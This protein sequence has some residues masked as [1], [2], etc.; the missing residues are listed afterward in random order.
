MGDGDEGRR[1]RMR[2]TRGQDGVL[3]TGIQGERTRVIGQRR[4]IL[5]APGKYGDLSGS[6]REGW[7][8]NVRTVS[9]GQWGLG[10]G[11]SEGEGWDTERGAWEDEEGQREDGGT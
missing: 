10:W 4:R 3:E 6:W 1:K 7:G 8:D 5:G 11:E 9:V 2:K